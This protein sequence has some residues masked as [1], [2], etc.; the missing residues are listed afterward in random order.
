MSKKT[1]KIPVL[2]RELRDGFFGADTRGWKFKKEDGLDKLERKAV[3]PVLKIGKFNTVEAVPEV[4]YPLGVKT[5]DLWIDRKTKAEIKIPERLGSLD[6]HIRKSKQQTQGGF[7]VIST[8]LLSDEDK[9]KI[10]IKEVI[11]SS[12]RGARGFVV[13]GGNYSVWFYK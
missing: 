1:P 3:A 9:I 7:L 10:K 5:P 6:S 4:D 8:D 13:D 11:K 12:R 2:P